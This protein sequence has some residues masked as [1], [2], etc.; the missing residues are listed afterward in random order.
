MMSPDA[1][2]A[3]RP[4]LMFPSSRDITARCL[5]TTRTGA[6]RALTSSARKAS[7]RC[8]RSL[9]SGSRS[10]DATRTPLTP[11]DVLPPVDGYGHVHLRSTDRHARFR[12]HVTLVTLR[13]AVAADALNCIDGDG[14]VWRRQGMVTVRDVVTP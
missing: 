5:S 9:N 10:P 12:S 8:T 4:A 1:A 14:A 3:R 13:R 7:R 2:W 6:L 11:A